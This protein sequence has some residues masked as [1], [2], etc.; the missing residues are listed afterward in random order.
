MM[1]PAPQPRRYSFTVDANV[2]V[3][4]VTSPVGQELLENSLLDLWMAA[5]AFDE[6]TR[7][8]ERLLLK[9]AANGHGTLT[10]ATNRHHELITYAI[11][12]IERVP[13]EDYAQYEAEARDRV[14]GD[15]DDWHTVALALAFDTEIW[16]NDRHFLGCG[17][18]TWT[19]ETLRRRLAR[20]RA[21]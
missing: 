13:L 17:V 14:P 20:T 8:L 1:P 18:P 5:Y 21:A 7:H 19:N 4:L 11:N 10:Q 6:F 9:R 12:I 2:V 15:P 3:G 16:T